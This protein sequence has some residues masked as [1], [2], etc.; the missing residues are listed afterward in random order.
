TVPVVGPSSVT[1]GP[2]AIEPVSAQPRGCGPTRVPR[3]EG[4]LLTPIAR[5]WD[6]ELGPA[7]VKQERREETFLGHDAI[8]IPAERAMI[9]EEIEPI[10]VEVFLD[11][12][13]GVRNE[14]R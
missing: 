1:C 2:A 12:A 14:R 3:R 7:L 13:F 10:A 8:Q 11:H 9:A 5:R 6:T 4:I